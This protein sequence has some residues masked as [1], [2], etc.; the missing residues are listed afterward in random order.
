MARDWLNDI[1]DQGSYRQGIIKDALGPLRRQ[2]VFRQP[3]CELESQRIDR[4]QVKLYI[5]VGVQWAQ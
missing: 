1:A 3:S 5:L 2:P 4:L